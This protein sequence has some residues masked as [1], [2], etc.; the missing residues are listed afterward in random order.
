ML[1]DWSALSSQNVIA[2]VGRKRINQGQSTMLHHPSAK[3]QMPACV[4]I[5][6]ANVGNKN[7][8]KWK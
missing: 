5:A 7:C 3:G 4:W 6:K 1:H 2:Y 8:Q